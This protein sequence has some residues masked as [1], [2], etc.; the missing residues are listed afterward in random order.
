MIKKGRM[1]LNDSKAEDDMPMK[2]FAL[3]VIL[4]VLVST[5]CVT[6]ALAARYYRLLEKERRIYLGLRG[7]DSVAAQKY[8]DLDSPA[9][10]KTFYQGLWRNKEDDREEFEKRA[11][12]ACRE[13][14][15]YA[16]LTDDRIW[17][18]TRYGP[19]TK[20]EVITPQKRIGAKTREMV[21]PAEVWTYKAGGFMIDFVRLADAYKVIA[22][23][24]FGDDVKIPYFLE[25]DSDT[26]LE[27][28]KSQSLDFA[29]Q[30]GRFRQRRNLTRLELYITTVIDDTSG[31][32]FYR[33]IKV[34]GT[35]DRLVLEKNNILTPRDAA[36]GEFTDEVNLWLE[37]QRYRLVID[38]FDIKNKRAGNQS[39]WV[40]LLDYQDDAKEISDLIAVKLVDDA[41]SH[42]KFNKPVGRVIPIT[43]PRIAVHTP[44]YFY[45]EVYNLETRSGMHQLRTTYEIYNKAKM[46]KEIVD[47][48]IRDWFEPGDNA[49]LAAAY[50]PMDL[51]PG[52]YI[53]VIRAKDLISGRERTAVAEFELIETKNS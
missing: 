38:L 16:P 44:F 48:M 37:P 36:G 24:E 3:I 53:I 15:K 34:Y 50:H 28:E 29:I 26:T 17:L 42:E 46:K 23:S 6:N 10:R 45:V 43:Q 25:T 47:V 14:G 18:Y 19:P 13:F 33:S 41:F 12:Y 4:M 20:R 1:P 11:E 30:I 7:I 9:E 21:N 35:D 51:A 32:T 8:L 22:R 52:Q 2:R 31:V 49:Y 39:R 5:C 27:Y 40:D